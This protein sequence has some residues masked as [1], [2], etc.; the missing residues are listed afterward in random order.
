MMAHDTRVQ[1]PQLVQQQPQQQV[2]N[3]LD[4][5]QLPDD[6]WTRILRYLPSL[7]DAKNLTVAYTV[8]EKALHSNA[9]REKLVVATI[10]RYHLQEDEL[11]DL[12][13]FI[14]KSEN[15]RL[16]YFSFPAFAS[17]KRE[18]MSPE[19]KS[20]YHDAHLPFIGSF[21]HVCMAE[22]VGYLAEHTRGKCV[23]HIV[24]NRFPPA[25]IEAFGTSVSTS[26][27]KRM[28]IAVY[29]TQAFLG[30]FDTAATVMSEAEIFLHAKRFFAYM[31]PWEKEQM[32]SVLDYLTARIVDRKSSPAY[33]V[34]L[35]I[36]DIEFTTDC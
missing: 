19:F 3:I 36:Y 9:R 28:G 1:T 18:F 12:I 27:L 2:V 24:S 13:Q 30:Q 21:K 8:A 4:T 31:T 5:K 7:V 26:E 33:E 10:M 35:N 32:M 25:A 6:V 20:Q 11:Y 22:V 15:A 14:H 23:E 17:F 34:E 29:V 16:A